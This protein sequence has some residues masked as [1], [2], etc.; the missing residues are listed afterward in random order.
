MNR[1][2]LT[3]EVIVKSLLWILALLGLVYL[4]SVLGERFL[5]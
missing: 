2:G 3:G 5:T 4:L 1:H